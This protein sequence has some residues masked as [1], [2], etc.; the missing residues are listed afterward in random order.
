MYYYA[1]LDSND[2]CVGVFESLTVQ[3]GDN[4]IQ[5]DS[6]NEN[7][8]GLHYNRTTGGWETPEFSDLAAHSTDEINYRETN[9]KL[10]DVPIEGALDK[11]D[12]IA[13]YLYTLKD[14][15]GRSAGV[16]A[17][18][19]EKV[20]PEAVTTAEDGFKAVDYG[21]IVALLVAAVKELKAAG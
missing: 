11:L 13:G 7:L 15:E 9:Q 21:A 2:I 19:V 18:E 5:I 12:A 6:L 17:Q 8:I 16:I 10:S 1:E 14:T 4:L 3:T 20:L